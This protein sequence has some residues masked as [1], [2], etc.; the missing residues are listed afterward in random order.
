MPET[1]GVDSVDEEDTKFA[2][3]DADAEVEGANSAD[4]RVDAA[5]VDNANEVD[6]MKKAGFKRSMETISDQLLRSQ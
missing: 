1:E 4:V 3:G 5:G 6:A 2:D